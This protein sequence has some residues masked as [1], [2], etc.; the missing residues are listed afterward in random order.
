RYSRDRE[1]RT[2]LD[3]AER[4]GSTRLADIIR[5]DVYA[6]AKERDVRAVMALLEQGVDPNARCPIRDFTALIASVFNKDEDMVRALLQH[7]HT[8]PNRPGRHGMTPLM[9]AAQA[10]HERMVCLLLQLKA[11]RQRGE[12][13][14]EIA[15]VRRFDVVVNIL[16]FDPQRL[17]VAA[18]AARNDW[19]AIQGLVAQGVSVNA[20]RVEGSE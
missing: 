8:D 19:P 6:A 2:A 16:K 20:R 4:Y 18:C 10:G 9:Y 5:V 13:A 1:G 15:S 14:L 12:S 3:W 11:D 17:S 7:P